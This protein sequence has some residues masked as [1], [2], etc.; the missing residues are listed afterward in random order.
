VGSKAV[1]ALAAALALAGADVVVAPARAAAPVAVPGPTATAHPEQAE[2][3][4]ITEA[5][6]EAIRTGDRAALDRHLA[7]EM[8]LV[9]RDGREYSRQDLL[10]ELVP[11]REG[12]DLRFRVLEPRVIARGESAL[13]TFIADEHLVIFG[14]DVSTAYRNHFLFHRLEGEWKLAL[15]TYWEKPVT[16]AAIALAPEV[17]D[18]YAGTYELAPGK[19][20]TRITR[21]GGRLM[22][23]RDAGKPRELIPASGERFVLA[24]VEAEYFFERD[25][26]G[27]PMALVFRRNWKDLRHVR[28]K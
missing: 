20:V 26:T 25:S 17:L 19:W 15:Y 4:R 18:S 14:H 9:N 11:P 5:I 8:L 23:Q 13:F 28:V 1:R 3:T 2:L 22:F 10:D 7:P 16:P 27:R 24:G 6:L 12:Y 21:E